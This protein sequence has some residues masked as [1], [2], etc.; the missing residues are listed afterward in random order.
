MQIRSSVRRS[1]ALLAAIILATG[2][3]GQGPSESAGSA[4]EDVP[5]APSP[6]VEAWVQQGG[7]ITVGR[8]T[9]LSDSTVALAQQNGWFEDFGLEI[10]VFEGRGS[11]DLLPAFLNG[12][13]DV[14]IGGLQP[15]LLSAIAGG[16]RIRAVSAVT[17]LD[18]DQ[19]SNYGLMMLPEA[20]AQF[21]PK[22]AGYLR[23]LRIGGP[24]Q[25]GFTGLWA[26]DRLAADIGLS[27][28]DL[29]LQTV[30]AAES[31]ATLSGGAVDAVLTGDP[32]MAI[33]R[34]QLGGVEVL[35]VSQIL[36]GRVVTVLYFGP[37]LLEDRELAARYLAVHVLTMR[38]H[39]QGATEQNVAALTGP[40]G[41]EPDLLSAMCWT[42]PKPASR[43][44]ETAVL[45]AM[46]Y[47]VGS[48]LLDSILS[49][50]AFWDH[51][52]LDLAEEL[53]RSSGR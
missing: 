37:R 50:E 3:S 38:Q 17:T 40:T 20:A 12:S 8:Q 34:Q 2:C 49:P 43:P 4:A 31:G 7:P 51:D 18:P 35:P 29:D 47:A 46:T 41:L 1:S 27:I 25:G 32:M 30:S 52:L 53:L 44:Y 36:P 23:N 13:I 14:M 16:A 42:A 9:T 24:F 33:I 26:V 45:E 39:A 11:A 19:C 10:E 28:D 21:D 15:G 48:G 22:D 6:V 5:P